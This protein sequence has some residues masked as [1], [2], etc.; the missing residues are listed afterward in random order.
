MEKIA[1]QLENVNGIAR[2]NEPVGLGIP[3]VKG[4]VQTVHNLTLMDDQTPLS[5]QLEPLAHWPDGSIRWVHASFLINLDPNSKKSLVLAQ[6]QVPSTDASEPVI[7]H[8]SENLVIHTST[9]SVVLQSRSLAWQVFNHDDAGIPSTVA[10]SD[11]T[12]VPCSAK[13]KA[14]WEITR[15]GPVFVAVVLKGEWL[16]LNN[17]PL[18]RFQCELR[19]FVETGLIQVELVTHNPKRARHP[20]GL[21][22]LGDPGSV[23]FRELAI[24]TTLPASSNAKVTPQ[25]ID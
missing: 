12:S 24:E 1:I 16:K 8:S 22:D 9:G 6:Q 23:Y 3:L 13:A 17:E 4:T 11:E 14:D 15:K 10:M 20:G 25:A 19:I 18:A 21:W 2:I 5:V 7:R